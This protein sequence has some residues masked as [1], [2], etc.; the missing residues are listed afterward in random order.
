MMDA[1]P[2]RKQLQRRASL[3][4]TLCRGSWYGI[5]YRQPFNHRGLKVFFSTGFNTRER[6][7]VFGVQFGDIRKCQQRLANPVCLFLEINREV[8]EVLA[9]LI[10]PV[11]PGINPQIVLPISLRL[12]I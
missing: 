2:F 9:G 5:S 11:A 4:L 8:P 1:N 3:F 7:L 12:A 10:S 6:R